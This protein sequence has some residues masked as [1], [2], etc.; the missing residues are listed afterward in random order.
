MAD[1]FIADDVIERR[2]AAGLAASL[3]GAAAGSGRGTTGPDTAARG[4]GSFTSFGS[5]G[6]VLYRRR[7]LA[8]AILGGMLLLALAYCL[9]AP[10]QYE[11]KARLALRV[12]PATELNLQGG[13]S[14]AFAGSLVT[15]QLQMETLAN[16]FRSDQLAWRVILEKKLYQA[17]GFLG[18]FMVRFPDF[19]ADKPSPDAEAYLLGRFQAR[20]SVRT[21]PRTL[22]L[23]IRFRSK[24][25]VLSAD[26]V[27]ALIRAFEQQQSEAR[28]LATGQ[29][30]AWMD[31][32]LRDLKSR[33][34]GDDRRLAEFEKR[35][36]ILISPESLG[37]G[38]AGSTQHLAAL[39]E[40]D[41]LG[42]A[43]V[44]ASTE[45]ILREAEYRAAAEGDPELVLASDP[46]LEMESGL[47]LDAFKRIRTRQ[48]DLEEERARLD[49]E[50]GPNFPRVLEIRNELDDLDRQLKA[51]DGRLRA[52]FKSAWATAADRE[53]LVRKGLE[54][55]TGEGLRVNEAATQY[56]AMR[57][58]ADASRA[59]YTRMKDKLEEAGLAAGVA[60]S[61]LWVVDAAHVPAH[62]VAPN[63]PLTM[64]ITGFAGLWLALAGALA[65]EGLRRLNWRTMGMVFVVLGTGLAGGV[66]C[67]A[68]APTPST[69]GLPSGV[70]RTP[71]SADTKSIP[72]AKGAP[73]V[74]GTA[75]S[76]SAL[77]GPVVTAGI[78][79]VLGPIGPGDLLD[80]SEF[81]TP[82]FHSTVRVSNAGAV[83]LPMVGEVNVDGM[84]EPAAVRV[85]AAAL[86]AKG[87]LK[88]PQVAV[89]VTQ[90][91]G[92]D[93]T[94]L[95]EVGRPGVY[96][97]GAHHRLF[98]A[99]SEAS[100]MS[101]EAGGL[102]NIFHR[103]DPSTAHA[104]TVD[105]S[106][107]GG[108]ERN[109]ELAPGDTVE[110]SR[111][112]LVY[113]VG[114]VIRPGGFTLEPSQ[115]MTV[116]KALSL[117]WG[118]SQNAAGQKALLIHEGNGGR[119]VTTLNIN[120]MLRGQDP[121]APVSERDILFVPDS[122]AKNLLNRTME[123]V[124]QS[125]AGVSIY[126]GLVYSQRF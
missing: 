40:V 114:D 106:A 91:M 9:V 47:S 43:L 120:R 36:G 74:W 42:R 86:V 107:A 89:L 18:R 111:A 97:F 112:G 98:D 121:D 22:L 16:V 35:H 52:R 105:F 41:E 85:I 7:R 110:V 82:E 26:V 100:G 115:Q 66:V 103:D 123:S 55:Q 48:S 21:V 53:K 24:D 50:H 23:E 67:R 20:L 29:A 13:E 33:T 65:M 99:I 126:A 38:Q 31:G 44:A 70:S 113:V 8:G 101:A 63:V 78:G 68:Q 25:A 14:A 2:G 81:Q 116:L 37:N 84:D 76:G 28:V 30:A 71:A 122:M 125:A 49:A 59:L 83:T 87:M 93:V 90:S 45:R 58:D 92:Q 80:V 75:S 62:P 69:S 4:G 60:G 94:V 77:N 64:A 109:P 1:V 19:R 12:S 79:E 15:G 5:V 119:T 32:Q 95:G 104:V 96:S 57:R 117:A 118:P 11:A 102:V 108:S 39:E 73:A 124:V 72:N 6:G 51:E 27:N 10:K 3:A 46:R 17:P 61:E 34:D 56:E 88:H 54:E